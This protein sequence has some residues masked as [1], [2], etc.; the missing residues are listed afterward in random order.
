MISD[1]TGKY[2]NNRGG[3]RVTDNTPKEFINTVYMF[4]NSVCYGLGTDD[5]NTIASILQ[6]EIQKYYE[7]DN[8][9]SVLN[10]ANGGGLNCYEQWKSFRYHM[11]QDGDIAVFIM[12][13]S[14]LLKEIYS[15]QFLWYDAADILNRPHNMGDIYFDNCHFNAVGY[16]ACGEY[17]MQSLKNDNAFLPEE[18]L[19][20]VRQNN[21]S[22]GYTPEFSEQQMRE[23]QEYVLSLE[24]HRKETRKLRRPSS[25]R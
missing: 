13:F 19:R 5:E 10:C 8:I 16:K 21:L 1:S 23:L 12:K 17:L 3:Y 11:P 2:V 18:E 4:G 15:Q 24:K 7:N 9:Y 14:N 22:T 20:K 6:K 25:R